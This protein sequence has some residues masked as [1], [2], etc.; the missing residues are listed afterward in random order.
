MGQ[1][2]GLLAG[3]GGRPPT[4]F[5][6]SVTAELS[7]GKWCCLMGAGF[8]RLFTLGL[9]GMSSE[10]CSRLLLC[11][12]G[13]VPVERWRDPGVAAQVWRVLQVDGVGLLGACCGWRS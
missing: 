3:L 6:V 1:N 12:N 10:G 9:C 7:G 13:G 2:T 11:G 8:W 5:T 4:G